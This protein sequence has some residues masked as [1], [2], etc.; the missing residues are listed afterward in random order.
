MRT[1]LLDRRVTF[2]EAVTETGTSNE[3]KITGWEV[4]ENNNT[5]W[6]QKIESSGNTVV[7]DDRVTWSQITKWRIR[8]REDLTVNL[9]LVF[10]S[11][12]YSILNITKDEQT[13]DRYLMLTT[14]L[15][16]NE[17]FT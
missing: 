15:L 2:I 8:F 13:R 11:Q 9:R 6:A 5:V 1:G 10:D 4:I 3:V 17:Y 12:V 14:N 16:D 7:A